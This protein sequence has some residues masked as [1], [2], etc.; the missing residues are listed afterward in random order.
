MD[1]TRFITY[2]EI[3]KAETCLSTTPFLSLEVINVLQMWESII[4]ISP[5]FQD[6][7]S[8]GD[9]NEKWKCR[10]ETELL[11]MDAFIDPN[12]NFAFQ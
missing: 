9:N 4:E 12:N 1:E 2:M 3:L 6:S 5:D 8:S 11:E 7:G 10:D